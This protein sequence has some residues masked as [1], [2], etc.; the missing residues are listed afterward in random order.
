M[1]NSKYSKREVETFVCEQFLQKYPVTTDKKYSLR[2]RERPDFLCCFS[3]PDETIG[4]EITD[5]VFSSERG[6]E[7]RKA[8]GHSNTVVSFDD[9]N[10]K[11]QMKTDMG[12]P[13]DTT[14]NSSSEV[15]QVIQN[16]ITNKW[17]VARNY[18]FDSKLILVVSWRYPIFNDLKVYLEGVSVPENSVFAEVWVIGF[19]T[20]YLCERIVENWIETSNCIGIYLIGSSVDKSK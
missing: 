19:K 4:I 14:R 2:E 7:A 12:S 11:E 16:A 15:T 3:D 20:S 8:Y 17:K 18:T 5:A 10:W 1:K 6:L 13:R 9:P